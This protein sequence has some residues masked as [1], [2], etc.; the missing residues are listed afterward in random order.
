[1]CLCL[2]SLFSV[3]VLVV[4]FNS[5]MIITTEG[6]NYFQACIVI[7]NGSIDVGLNLPIIYTLPDEASKNILKDRSQNIHA[8]NVPQYIYDSYLF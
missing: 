6:D 5:S 3:S 8:K 7:V 2:F 1:M 4:A